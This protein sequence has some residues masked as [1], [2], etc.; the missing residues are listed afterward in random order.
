MA[1]VLDLNE[2][3]IVASLC[4]MPEADVFVERARIM[5]AQLSAG[6]AEHLRVR[7]P[8]A[9]DFEADPTGGGIMGAFAPLAPDDAMPNVFWPFD[10]DGEWETAAAIEQ[11]PRG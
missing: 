6:M 1:K 10:R 2:M 8:I 9:I 7:G 4:G 5:A 11:T 3:L